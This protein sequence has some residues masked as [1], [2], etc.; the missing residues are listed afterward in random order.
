MK[1]QLKSW[2]GDMTISTT[3]TVKSLT[4]GKENSVDIGSMGKGFCSELYYDT[5][6]RLVWY[7][8][9]PRTPGVAPMTYFMNGQ[10]VGEP[11]TDELATRPAEVKKVGAK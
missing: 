7:T 4:I 2:R 1:I 10:G 5:D 9:T 8:I 11:T 3:S 6:S